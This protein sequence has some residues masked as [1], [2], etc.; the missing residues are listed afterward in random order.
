MLAREIFKERERKKD[1]EGSLEA[2]KIGKEVKRWMQ[3][4]ERYKMEDNLLY[5]V[6]ETDEQGENQVTLCVPQGESA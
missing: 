3:L 4:A 2:E 5:R 6:D 1:E